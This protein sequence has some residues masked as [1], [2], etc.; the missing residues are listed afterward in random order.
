MIDFLRENWAAILAAVG[1]LIAGGVI[2]R[3]VR[4]RSGRDST[5]TNQSGATAQGDIV[6][7]DKIT[8]GTKRP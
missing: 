1:A 2:V 6:G 5:I 4:A 3:M 8:G 7:R